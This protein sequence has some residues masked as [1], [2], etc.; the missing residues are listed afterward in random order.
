M[1][2]VCEHGC[3]R[4]QCDLCDLR[5]DLDTAN[6]EIRRLTRERAEVAAELGLWKQAAQVNAQALAEA[7]Q[8]ADRL[9]RE[10][11]EAV[12][13]L[14]KA[15]EASFVPGMMRCAKCAFVLTRVNLHVNHGT[16]SAGDNATEPCPNGCGPL[17]PMTWQDYAD[18]TDAAVT[19]YLDERG[20]TLAECARLREAVSNA[21][22]DVLSDEAM[23]AH[24]VA[25]LRAALSG[26]EHE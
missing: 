21:L 22:D 14:A 25:L 23:P 11:D 20:A 4:R 24:K 26:G 8:D 13:A 18:G 2:D 1:S 6:L 19:R 3:L 10:R 7:R 16:T 17:W 15:R 5:S 12:A 9:T